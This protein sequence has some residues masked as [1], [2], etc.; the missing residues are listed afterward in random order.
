MR[1]YLFRGKRL[2][3]G[4][5][6]EGFLTSARTIGVVSPIGNYGEYVIDPATVGQYTGLKDKHGK[7]IFEGDVL[8]NTSNPAWA[9][10]LVKYGYCK[11]WVVDDFTDK[12]ANPKTRQMKKCCYITAS[13]IIYEVIGNIHNNPE[14]LEATT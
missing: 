11:S 6:V 2:D 13:D 7:R 14:L 8:R 1:E 10:Q 9:L 4:E 3:N 5:W 12:Q